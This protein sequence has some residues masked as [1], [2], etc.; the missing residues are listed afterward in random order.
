MSLSVIVMLCGFIMFIC[1]IVFA[2]QQE[3]SIS[4][5]SEAAEKFSNGSFAT[6][7]IF[8]LWAMA[9]GFSGTLC[10]CK[11][12]AEGS[13]C[14]PIIYGVTLFVAWIMFV[15]MGAVVTSMSVTGPE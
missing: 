3:D 13:I 14:W 12:C 15:I 4:N 11:W 6:L 5:V 2:S 9:V 10:F 8:S 7:L 1:S